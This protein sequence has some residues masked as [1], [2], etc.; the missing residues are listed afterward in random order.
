MDVENVGL[1]RKIVNEL[2]SRLPEDCAE[3]A[4]EHFNFMLAE[5]KEKGVEKA[6]RDW[7][8]G[9]S[10]DLEYSLNQ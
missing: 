4:N 2:I 3:I 8:I 1:I 7:Y 5:I 9:D 6:T 10:E